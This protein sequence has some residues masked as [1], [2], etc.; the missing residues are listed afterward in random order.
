MFRRVL[1]IVVGVLLAAGTLFAL[2]TLLFGSVEVPLSFDATGVTDIQLNGGTLTLSD[3]GPAEL[4]TR[5]PLRTLVVMM[6]RHD[7]ASSMSVGGFDDAD[8]RVLLMPLLGGDV[9]AR[10]DAI[11][12]TLGG[13]RVEKVIVAGG[14]LVTERYAARAFAVSG[15][16]GAAELGGLDVGM[17]AAHCQDGATVTLAGRADVYGE[18]NGGV[19]VDASALVYDEYDQDAAVGLLGY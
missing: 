16:A 12:W 8:P 19:A 10:T 7:S 13:G 17:L 2:A 5:V 6:A 15:I 18:V 1:L 3:D 14:T 11:E 4:R 9:P